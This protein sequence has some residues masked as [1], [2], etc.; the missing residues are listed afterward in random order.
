V[1]DS[2]TRRDV[3]SSAAPENNAV[4]TYKDALSSDC[5]SLPRNLQASADF[6]MDRNVVSQVSTTPETL[7]NGNDVVVASDGGFTAVKKSK[8]KKETAKHF[9][10]LS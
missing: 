5:V 2:L 7:K 4:K 6:M 10:T 8:A 3:A 9:S 1:Q